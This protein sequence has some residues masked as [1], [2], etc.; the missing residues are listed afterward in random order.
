MRDVRARL[1]ALLGVLAVA[2]GG[3]TPAT[4]AVAP[5]P[6]PP[7]PPAAPAPP[8]AEAAEAPPMEPANDAPQQVEA[9]PPE[10][11]P[12]QA[13][14]WLGVELEPA[15]DEGGVRITNVIPR[16]P[17]E[18]AGLAAGDVLIRIEGDAVP[19]PTNVVMAVGGR[20]AG[21][22]TSSFPSRSARN[23]TR[24]TSCG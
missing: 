4:V 19:T 9:A 16:S 18:S 20:N 2:C 22:P 10:A 3:S 13:Q 5:P 1:R 11:A 24:T 15:P 17:A 14:G 8:P 21:A 12:K 7:A 23:R 6:P